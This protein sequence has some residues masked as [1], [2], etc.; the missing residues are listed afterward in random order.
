MF[1]G[2]ISAH[3]FWVVWACVLFIFF[4]VDLEIIIPTLHLF[5]LCPFPQACDLPGSATYTVLL[6]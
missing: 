3:Y 5:S 4:W 2:A 6:H 1:R